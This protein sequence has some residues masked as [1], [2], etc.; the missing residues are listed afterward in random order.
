[1]TVRL[2]LYSDLVRGFCFSSVGDKVD[3]WTVVAN[4]YTG[5][6]RWH[7]DHT[8]V[9]MGKAHDDDMDSFWAFDYERAAGE[10]NIP[11]QFEHEFVELYQVTPVAKSI[12]IYEKVT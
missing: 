5:S 2:K 11:D 6:R 10:S 7:I 3:G 9:V 1:M 12:V 8:V 4:E